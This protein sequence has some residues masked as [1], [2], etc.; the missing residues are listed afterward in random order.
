MADPAISL[1]PEEEAL[2]DN[3]AKKGV[4]EIA[5][6]TPKLVVIE[7]GA[8]SA[9]T[10]AVITESAALE[11]TAL[12]TAEI[13][14]SRLFSLTGIGTF[15]TFM[16]Y[17]TPAGETPEQLAELQKLN[18]QK[19]TNQSMNQSSA[20]NENLAAPTQNKEAIQKCVRETQC[21]PHQW[22]IKNQGNSYADAID[23]LNNLIDQLKRTPSKKDVLRGY[24]FEKKAMELNNQKR[25]V[26]YAG[27]VL[28]CEICG[29]EQE[30]DLEF[31]DGQIAE[32]KSSKSSNVNKKG[33]QAKRILDIQNSMNCQTGK[34]FQPL[35]KLDANLNDINETSAIFS[36]RN[37][38]IEKI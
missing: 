29:A 26:A 35:A 30:I 34:N 14:G 28:V 18:A 37:F 19:S 23:N 15:L 13:A 5:R 31:R 24:E 16:F 6:Q 10:S 36:R 1:L 38:E 9:T 11:S 8:G 17:S 22:K 33:N 20:T 27:K 12:E 25:G 2:L 32:S 21:P 7:G 4:S 3:V